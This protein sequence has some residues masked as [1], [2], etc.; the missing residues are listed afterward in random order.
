[1]DVIFLRAGQLA[2]FQCN[3]D[4]HNSKKNISFKKLP[5]ISCCVVFVPDKHL[6]FCYISAFFLTGQKKN[7]YPPGNHHASHL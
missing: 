3:Y 1:M 5:S 4:S 6:L 2:L 7:Q